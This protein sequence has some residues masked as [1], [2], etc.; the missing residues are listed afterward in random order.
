MK[1][2][3]KFIILF[4][5][6]FYYLFYLPIC[7]AQFS[8]QNSLPFVETTLKK[9]SEAWQNNDINLYLSLCY[10]K[11]NEKFRLS[12]EQEML[13]AQ[14]QI[15]LDFDN[16]CTEHLFEGIFPLSTD[17]KDEIKVAF[18]LNRSNGRR[19][20]GVFKIEFLGDS[21]F[22]YL[23]Y[24]KEFSDFTSILNR[25]GPMRSGPYRI[26]NIPFL[27]AN[28]R[29]PGE[30]RFLVLKYVPLPDALQN[31]IPRGWFIVEDGLMKN[32][33]STVTL[34]ITKVETQSPDLEKYIPALNRWADGLEEE[35]KS[36]RQEN[37]ML[38]RKNKDSGIVTPNPKDTKGTEKKDKVK[39]F[40][41]DITIGIDIALIINIWTGI[42]H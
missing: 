25:I 33:S 21:K 9:W 14:G 7:S 18:K 22:S 23:N 36:L 30:E 8:W 34:P 6:I 28:R 20:W 38:V 19:Q 10:P 35:N 29:V 2:L 3:T 11:S 32:C 27:V 5:F 13:N 41:R 12:F 26:S 4:L 39:F 1:H 42:F 24:K 15:S 40:F 17:T 37:V 16:E 31:N